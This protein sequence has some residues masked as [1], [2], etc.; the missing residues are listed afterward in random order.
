MR[1]THQ[2]LLLAWF[3]KQKKTQQM[4]EFSHDWNEMQYSLL[5]LVTRDLWFWAWMCFSTK[6]SA[7]NMLTNTKLDTQASPI[8]DDLI[9]L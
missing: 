1:L 3:E 7:A 6:A 4:K 2:F 8:I 9:Y 5:T